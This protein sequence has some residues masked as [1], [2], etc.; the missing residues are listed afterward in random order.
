MQTKCEIINAKLEANQ[1]EY[2]EMQRV[3]TSQRILM[4]PLD[5]S[6]DLLFQNDVLEG[7]I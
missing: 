3:F 7:Q 1:S 6:N 4:E 2:T 5:V